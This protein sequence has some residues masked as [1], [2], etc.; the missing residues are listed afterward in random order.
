[1]TEQDAV[2]AA[3]L[4][5]LEKKVDDGR[6][7]TRDDHAAVRRDLANLTKEVQEGNGITREALRIATEARETADAT[8]GIVSTHLLTHAKAEGHQDGQREE[9]ARWTAPFRKAV[10]EAPKVLIAVALFTA[11]GIGYVINYVD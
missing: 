4:D 2:L 5:G 11:G 8:A 3:R 6:K 7:E 9:R 10:D 1:M